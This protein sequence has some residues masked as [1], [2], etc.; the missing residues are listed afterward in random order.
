MDPLTKQFWYEGLKYANYNSSNS[1]STGYRKF[2]TFYGITPNVFAKLWRLITEKPPG[3][4]PK[5]LL[6][7]L[8]FLKNYNTE[9]VNAAIANVDEKTFRLW[10]WRFVNLLA[11]LNVVSE[12]GDLKQTIKMRI[13]LHVK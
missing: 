12:I 7:C 9:H 13:F 8:F 11:E 2:R 1:I 10:N 5:H 3:S 4:E 6:W